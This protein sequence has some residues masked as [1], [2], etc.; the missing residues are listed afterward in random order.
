MVAS[1]LLEDH[2]E[3]SLNGKKEDVSDFSLAYP[4]LESHTAFFFSIT[5][6]CT[7]L[8]VLSVPLVFHMDSQPN[9]SEAVHWS[10]VDLSPYLEIYRATS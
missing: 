10:P 6:I 7:F 8:E 4:L 1:I 2:D 9:L 5:L 3:L